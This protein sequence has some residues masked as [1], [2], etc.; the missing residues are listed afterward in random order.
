MAITAKITVIT[1]M[2]ITAI[3]AII[4]TAIMATMAMATT[5][6]L[7]TT[8]LAV[9]ATKV[10]VVAVDA[11][12]ATVDPSPNSTAGR[13]VPVHTPAEPAILLQLAIK[14]KLLLTADWV[15]ASQTAI[16]SPDRSGPQITLM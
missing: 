7:T 15:A 13:M 4:P 10:V 14:P 11:S 6:A 8:T 2:V 1:A 16:G 9:E 3:M 12:M 5:T